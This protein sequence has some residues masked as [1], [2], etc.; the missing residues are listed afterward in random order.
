MA[1]ILS[2]S[3]P[4]LAFDLGLDAVEQPAQAGLE[5]LPGR[6]EVPL[7]QRAAKPWVLARVEQGAQLGRHV[8][9]AGPDR[10]GTT[11][12]LGPLAG[13]DRPQGIADRVVVDAG[14]VLAGDP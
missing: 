3:R 5:A 6:S 11:G 4:P 10:V 1:P 2:A 7:R 14:Q 9:D 12:R 13:A 8:V